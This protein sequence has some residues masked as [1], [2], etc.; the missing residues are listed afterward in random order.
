MADLPPMI[1]TLDD[2]MA[3]AAY[4]AHCAMDPDDDHYEAKPDYRQFKTERMVWN[5]VAA[6]VIRAG[7]E[8]IA[9]MKDKAAKFDLYISRYIRCD[10]CGM[11]NGIAAERGLTHC[12]PPFEVKPHSFTGKH[13][14]HLG[15]PWPP[16]VEKR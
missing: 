6:A 15:K 3:W 7:G 2:R 8:Y 13:V 5:A 1:T 11:E 14:S 10:H 12:A 16:V 9:E 4:E